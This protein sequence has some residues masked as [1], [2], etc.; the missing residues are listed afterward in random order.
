MKSI[1]VIGA[2]ISGLSCLHYLNQQFSND[3]NCR[4]T[5][6][7]QADCP[8]GTVQTLCENGIIFEYGPNGFLDS[9]PATLNLSEELGLS[10]ELITANPEAKK[11]FIVV[12]DTLIALPLSPPAFFASSLFSLAQKIRFL[13]EIGI[14]ST[15]SPN[16]SMY[17]FMERRLGR[18][19]GEY[20]AVPMAKGIYAGDAR[21]IAIEAAFPKIK[22]I[23]SAHGSLI[24]YALK[25]KRKKTRLW[26]FKKGMRQII[27]TLYAKYQNQIKLNT[28]VSQ[29]IK[30]NDGIVIKT[31]TG[32]IDAN[33]VILSTAAHAASSIIEPLNPV[34]AKTL[35]EIQYAP[36]GVLGIVLKTNDFPE[37]PKG[38]G[39]LYPGAIQEN[40]LLGVL[41]ESDVFNGRCGKDEVLLRAMLSGTHSSINKEQ[42]F[43]LTLKALEKI[44]KHPLLIQHTFFKFWEK[45]IPQYDLKYLNIKGRIE[46][47]LKS[48]PELSLC[49]N[50]YGGVTF[51]DCVSNAKILAEKIMPQ[52]T[53]GSLRL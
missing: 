19:C 7:E 50:Y 24:R 8:G 25:S 43:S 38:F 49:A 22:N 51:N 45:A 47:A 30:T 20:L 4:V 5:L 15:S 23:E 6:L 12:N 10:H 14:S 21:Q 11:R 53:S 42:A 39:F 33:H 17:A 48:T 36:V 18:A 26:S 29:I 32:N 44:Y 52:T 34:L 31:S 41:F 37:K 40:P 28:R 35:T 16:E 27:D 13:K 9:N 1:V 3:A 2:G 46:A